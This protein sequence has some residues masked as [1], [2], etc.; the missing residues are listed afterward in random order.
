M[1]DNDP[2]TNGGLPPK[3]SLKPKS[4]VP[5]PQVGE[6][7]LQKE[8]P[9]ASAAEEPRKPVPLRKPVAP[10]GP[11]PILPPTVRLEKQDASAPKA[12]P[13]V[14][15]EKQE[16]SAPKAPPT[17]PLEKQEA[18]APKAPPTVPLEKQ[19]APAP[20]APP[21]VR[22]EKQDAPAPKAPA[23]EK[24]DEKD[25][26]DAPVSPKR[27]VLRPA[28]STP[29]SAKRPAPIGIRKDA[30]DPLAAPGTKKSTSR[31]TLPSATENT[32]TGQIKTIKIAP[33][34]QTANIEGQTE[35]AS[36]PASKPAV[37]A[38]PKRQTSRISLESV[39]G[40]KSP[41]APATIKIKRAQPSSGDAAS[42]RQGTESASEPPSAVTGGPSQEQ[43]Q[44]SAGTPESQKK[45]LK[46]RRPAV[47]TSDRPSVSDGQQ[48]FT[49]PV[50]ATKPYVEEPHWIFSVVT[51]AATLVA[52]VL[53]YV[54]VAQVTDPD[55]VEQPT[56]GSGLPWPAR[57]AQ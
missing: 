8:Q 23:T 3:I 36:S 57:L 9:K 6:K 53:I 43:T 29:S 34:S 4:D 11:K 51:I 19:E 21:T 39:L 30:P 5:T 35:N 24:T 18:P 52:G 27:P 17:V 56:P 31:I 38:D 15:L 46:V 33:R 13:T 12:P 40:G 1:S 32:T 41:N 7:G 25:D 16:A 54:L 37:V 20:K 22:L 47:A 49:P 48:M 2:D 26:T 55:L 50:A 14:P 45:T 28:G 44:T 10:D 42:D